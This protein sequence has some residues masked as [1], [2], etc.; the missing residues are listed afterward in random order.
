MDFIKLYSNTVYGLSDI[1][2]WYIDFSETGIN[3][4]SFDIST[5]H[6]LYNKISEETVLEYDNLYYK[7][8]TINERTSSNLSTITAEL[9]LDDLRQTAYLNYKVETKSFEQIC[10]DVEY[11]ILNNTNWTVNNISSVIGRRSMELQNCVPLDVLQHCCNATM[12]NRKF[13]FDNKNKIII[14]INIEEKQPTGAYFTDELNLS[15]M[16]FKGT[17]DGLVTRLYVYGKDI[18]IT[19]YA[20]NEYIE[21]HDYTDKVISAVWHDERYTDEYSLYIDAVEK[22]K[23]MSK[24]SRTYSCKVMDLSVLNDKYNFLNVNLYDIVTLID[25]NR[26]TRENHRVVNIKK[27]PLNPEQN[28]IT[29]SSMSATITNKLNTLSNDF[30]IEKIVN[31]SKWNEITRDISQNTANIG[32][33]YQQGENSKIYLSNLISQTAEKTIEQIHYTETIGA[34]NLVIHPTKFSDTSNWDIFGSA[35]EL[36]TED[37][38]LKITRLNTDE[39]S[40]VYVLADLSKPVSLNKSQT[41]YISVYARLK[42]SAPCRVYLCRKQT[43]P[44]TLLKVISPISVKASN[45]VTK[46]GDIYY[47]VTQSDTWVDIYAQIQ[48]D[49]TTVDKL[50]TDIGIYF[51]ADTTSGNAPKGLNVW[52]DYM[53][54]TNTPYYEDRITTVEKTAD[55]ILMEVSKKASNTDFELYKTEVSQKFDSISLTASN[56]STSSNISI[57]VNG[58]NVSSAD[59]KLT[60][61]VTFTHLS[62]PGSSNICGNNITT[63]TISSTDDKCKINLA[64]STIDFQTNYA[65]GLKGKFQLSPSGLYFTDEDGAVQGSFYPSAGQNRT[66]LLTH[67]I[68]IAGTK[69]YNKSIETS[70]EAEYSDNGVPTGNLRLVGGSTN[71][72]FKIENIGILSVNGINF[73]CRNGRVDINASLKVNSLTVGDVTFTTRYLS[74]EGIYVLGYNA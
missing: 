15:D 45:M 59:I 7:V 55:G 20:G 64:S 68:S 65:G 72:S 12:F 28:V 9:D 36:S 47:T 43:K 48:N 23:Q 34:E 19:K 73:D 61:M 13:K 62:T 2:N 52:L 11:G 44:S 53:Q 5:K 69:S 17:S 71:E 8:K 14:P 56:Q 60:G 42:T 6:K 39:T 38:Y 10:N 35:W 40:N 24:P 21:N 49:N 25:R 67:R 50:L 1:S 30:N 37:N 58:V 33:L 46:S 41:N 74:T 31:K 27:Y 70:F 26:N 29:L 3:T 54:V 57:S 66:Y 51:S 63:G 22:L 4:M 18:D 16:N 32:E